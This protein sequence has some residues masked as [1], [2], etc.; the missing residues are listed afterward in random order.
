M[1]DL[2][3]CWQSHHNISNTRLAKLLKCHPSLITL[4]KNG[5]RNWTPKR[6]EAMEVLSDGEVPRLQLLY[7][8]STQKLSFVHKVLALFSWGK[9][10]TI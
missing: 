5:E 6:A 4:L 2:V 1:E 9:P 10:P 3:A 8:D 7:P